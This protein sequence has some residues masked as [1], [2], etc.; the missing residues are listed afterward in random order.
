MSEKFTIPIRNAFDAITA[1][2]KVR[3]FAR[4]EGLDVTGQA[5]ISLA[6]YSLANA[7]SGSG[8]QGQ[9]ILRSLREDKRIGVEVI[10]VIPDATNY[11]FPA[12]TFKNVKWLVD[13]FAT[14]TLPSNEMQIA[15]TQWSSLPEGRL[16]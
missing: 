5:R 2:A 12:E 9:L 13:E 16:Q 11:Q 15:L 14:E 6:A 4:E 1:R 10:C 3:E 8:R 7:K